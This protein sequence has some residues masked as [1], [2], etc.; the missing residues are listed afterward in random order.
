MDDTEMD[1]ASMQ[2]KRGRLGATSRAEEVAAGQRPQA[3][4]TPAMLAPSMEDDVEKKLSEAHCF[5]QAKVVG[6]PEHRKIRLRSNACE[7]P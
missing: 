1:Y 6:Q 2:R 4:N 5:D 3:H 7:V